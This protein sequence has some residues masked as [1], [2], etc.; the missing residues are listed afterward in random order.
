MANPS[1]KSAAGAGKGAQRGAAEVPHPE[2][3]Q[4]IEIGKC[5]IDN[6]IVM[7]PMNVLM[8]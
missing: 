7:A 6:R 5:K 1:R 8:S 2:L 4:P 3:F